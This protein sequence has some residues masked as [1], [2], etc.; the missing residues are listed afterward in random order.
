MNIYEQQQKNK[1]LTVI[2]VIVFVLFFMII[3]LGFDY[4]YF[5]WQPFSVNEYGQEVKKQFVPYGTIIC[6][7]LSLIL[8]INAFSNG[9]KNIIS[10]TAAVPVNPNDIKEK[11]FIDVVEE[12]SIAAGIPKPASYIV[13]DR[14][15]NAFATGFSPQ[16]S[17]IFATRGL[18]ENLNREELQAVVAHEMS[19]IRFYDIRLLTVTTV[20][21]NAIAIISDMMW[22]SSRN[23]RYYSSGSSSSSKNKNSGGGLIFFVWIIL[24]IL[25][26]IIS[27]ILAM[28][29]SRQR[30]YL[31]DAGSAELTRNPKALV[32]ALEKI[33]AAVEPTK[34]IKDAVAHMCIADPK[35]SLIEEK[36]GF[37]AD[38]FATHP[39]MEKRI[40]ALKLMS[41]EK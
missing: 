37:W 15:L 21:M 23:A 36:T 22:R 33:R 28:A 13:P 31:A 25:A 5:N 16:K 2:L 8:V 9:I 4:F 6:S 10:S 12:M 20:L 39:P 17:Y 7:I 41:Y 3:G 38:L 24:V 40:L 32:S 29:I 30:E 1:R 14:D 27:R 19:H 26:P 34:T 11:Q 35:G 18:V